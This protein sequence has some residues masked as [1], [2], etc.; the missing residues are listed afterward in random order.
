MQQRGRGGNVL[1]RHF[2]GNA[3]LLSS[4]LAFLLESFALP[5]AGYCLRTTVYSAVRP[6]GRYLIAVFLLALPVFFSLAL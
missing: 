3:V 6:S 4:R 2:D 1:P 5:P